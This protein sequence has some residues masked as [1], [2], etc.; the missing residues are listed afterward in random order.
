MLNDTIG[1]YCNGGFKCE[2]SESYVLQKQ[3]ILILC[4]L[5]LTTFLPVIFHVL[6]VHGSMFVKYLACDFC[7]VSQCILRRVSM[8]NE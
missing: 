4:F 2:V 3:F 1:N 6:N 8:F 5:L 7:V